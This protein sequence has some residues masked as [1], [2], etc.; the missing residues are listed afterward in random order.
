ML[1]KGRL[2]FVEDSELKKL[3]EARKELEIQLDLAEKQ[4]AI[5]AQ[6]AGDAAI[7]AYNTEFGGEPGFSI[8]N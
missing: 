7:T 3:Q 4:E 6:K 5:A 2:T 1:Q 8:F